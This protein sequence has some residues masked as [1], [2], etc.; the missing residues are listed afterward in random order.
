M[1]F[2]DMIVHI[3]DAYP[4][5][6]FGAYLYTVTVVLIVFGVRELYSIWKGKPE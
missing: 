4:I 6:I 1:T 3:V 2:A 5:P